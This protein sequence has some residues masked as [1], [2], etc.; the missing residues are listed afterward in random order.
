M[1]EIWQNEPNLIEP[2]RRSG[3]WVSCLIQLSV[4]CRSEGVEKSGEL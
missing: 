3:F 1:M 4:R 2:V